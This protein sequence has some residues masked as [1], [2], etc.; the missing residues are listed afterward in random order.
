MLLIVAETIQIFLVAQTFMSST[1]RQKAKDEKSREVDMIS[2]FD[3]KDL[4][5][6][7]DKSNPIEREL[8]NTIQGSTNHYDIESYLHLRGN[9]FQENELRDCSHENAIPRQD[10]FLKTMQTFTNEINLR[11]FQEMDSMMSMMHSQIN[12]AISS[13]IA[14]RVL[15]EN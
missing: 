8:A 13:A 6:G 5:I 12:R 10:G 4:M 3:N 14:E 15:P 9:S 2:D 1:R 11:L 7:N